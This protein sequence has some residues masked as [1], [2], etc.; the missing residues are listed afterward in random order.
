LTKEELEVL[1][2]EKN[3]YYAVTIKKTF[4]D[5][6]EQ[7]HNRLLA[8]DKESLQLLQGE[9]RGISYCLN[10]MEPSFHARI[11][12]HAAANTS[13][14]IGQPIPMVSNKERLKIKEQATE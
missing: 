12:Q 10:L 13:A 5:A 1:T 14:P 6:K 2:L 7:I 11:M 8:A 4:L 3:S 9:L